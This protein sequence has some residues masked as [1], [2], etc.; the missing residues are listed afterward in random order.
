MRCLCFLVGVFILRGI[1][2]F[3]PVVMFFFLGVTVFTRFG[4]LYEGCG[5]W[6]HERIV[7]LAKVVKSASSGTNEIYVFMALFYNTQ[8]VFAC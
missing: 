6:Q 5:F 2:I 3:Y 1:S 7:T 8:V 4:I